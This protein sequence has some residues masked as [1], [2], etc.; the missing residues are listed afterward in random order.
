MINEVTLRKLDNLGFGTDIDSLESYIIDYSNAVLVS[1]L[2]RYE[3]NYKE[4]RKL[5]KELK[6]VSQA[7][8]MIPPPIIDNDDMDFFFSALGNERAPKA[9]GAADSRKV[10]RIKNQMYADEKDTFD[11][12][13]IAGCEGIDITVVYEKGY[14]KGIYGVSEVHKQ[15]DF[16]EEL[17]KHFDN[18]DTLYISKFAKYPIVEL[19]A[20]ATILKGNKILTNVICDTMHK[21]RTNIGTEDIELIYNDIFIKGDSKLKSYWNKLGYIETLGFKVVERALLRNIDKEEL[22]QAIIT[23]A[24]HMIDEV[25]TDYY[26]DSTYIKKN[27]DVATP[28]FIIDYDICNTSYDSVFESRVRSVTSDNLGQY[29][30]IVSIECNKNLQVDKIY[31]DDI[32]KLESYHIVP[33]GKIKFRIVEGK[34]ILYIDEDT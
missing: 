14:L 1:N 26:V 24:S 30:N 29:I 13:A 7:L 28:D 19:R 27:S 5:L 8:T 22:N 9:Y 16:T 15:F 10:A 32:Y 12:V 6:P 2:T 33:N 31:L 23:L 20:K 21:L 4:A 11:I 3:Y 18:S 34:A 25:K 17:F